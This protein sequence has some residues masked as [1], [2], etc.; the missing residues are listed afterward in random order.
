MKKTIVLTAIVLIFVLASSVRGAD[1]SYKSW[2]NSLKAAEQARYRRDFDGMRQILEASAPTAQQLGPLS[3]A[4]NSIWLAIAYSQLSRDADA[5]KVYNAELDRIGPN[6]TAIKVQF[7]RGFLLTQRSE[8]Y[9]RLR[10]YDKALASAND[11][12]AALEQA[13]GKFD[14]SLY[15]AHR[16]VGRIYALRNDMAKAE[17]AM[18][19]AVRLAETRQGRREQY[20]LL[21]DAAN[22]VTYLTGPLEAR[23]TVAASDLGE[24]YAAEGK[25]QDAEEAY[26]KALE[27]AEAVYS[28]D[29]VM[30]A[31][32]LLGLAE[33]EYH[34]NHTKSFE[35]HTQQLFEII[36]KNPGY[37]SAYVKP[38]WLK[39]KLET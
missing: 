31:I 32:P 37:E 12:K 10:E 34:L 23:V 18:R 27:H 9:F 7:I 17:E 15:E 13:V 39:F 28:S 26:K 38:L 25:F 6:P 11:G 24:L 3:S 1:A 16:T 22:T 21:G 2:R 30:R 19:M 20:G 29:N 5:L 8:L 4:E 33:V 35:K 14:P 36:S